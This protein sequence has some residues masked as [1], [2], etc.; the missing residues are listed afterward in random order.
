[1]ILPSNTKDFDTLA[2]LAVQKAFS[3][4][5]IEDAIVAVA[6]KYQLNPLELQRLMEKT[7]TLM[8]LKILQSGTDKNVEFDLAEYSST[9]AKF[10]ATENKEAPKETA[11]EKDTKVKTASL[12]GLPY[13]RNKQKL[14]KAVL[15]VLTKQASDKKPD[16][17]KTIFSLQKRAEELKTE[18]MAFELKVSNGIE[19]IISR[20]NILNGPDFYK[21][22]N[23]AYTI[24]GEKSS[25]VLKVIGEAIGEDQEAVKVAYVVDETHRDLEKMAEV[26]DTLISLVKTSQELTATEKL[27]SKTWKEAGVT[28]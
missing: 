9:L 27:L 19:D 25:G 3:G 22:A 1:M 15:P 2:E 23:E 13:T 28:L 6:D 7:N 14:S 5:N 8:S 24:F 4:T 10:M 26:L 16:I 11:V 18:K 21:F 20:Y 12:R 17:V